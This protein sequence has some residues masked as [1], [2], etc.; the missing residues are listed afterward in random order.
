MSAWEPI[1]T[2]PKDGAEIMANR[3][4]HALPL[5]GYGEPFRWDKA[6]GRWLQKVNGE[7]W[8][9]FFKPTHWKSPQNTSAN[10]HL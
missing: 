5:R 2:A 1:E 9:N 3:R 10:S 7:W 4:Y 8:P 6:R